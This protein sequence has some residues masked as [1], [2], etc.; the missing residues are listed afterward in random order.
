MKKSFYVVFFKNIKGLFLVKIQD[1]LYICLIMIT[2]Q[3]YSFNCANGFIAPQTSGVLQTAF[4]DEKE[5]VLVYQS[6]ISLNNSEVRFN[7]ALFANN[8]QSNNGNSAY[9]F[10]PVN[11]STVLGVDIDLA[12]NKINDSLLLESA[13]INFTDY[14]NFTITL[15][16]F[17]TYDL[18]NYISTIN[19]NN[20]KRLLAG[21]VNA[22]LLQ[23]NIPSAYNSPKYLGL[24]VMHK[25]NSTA[26]TTDRYDYLPIQATFLNF[27]VMNTPIFDLV[28]DGQPANVVSIDSPTTINFKVNYSNTIHKIKF[29]VIDFTNATNNNIDFLTAYRALLTDVSATITQS[30]ANTYNAF[31]IVPNTQ[32]INGNTYYIIA[33]C[34]DTVNNVVNSFVSEAF[35][36]AGT[37]LCKPIVNS[38]FK[39]YLNAFLPSNI[40]TSPYDRL[41]S[42]IKYTNNCSN[43]ET[44]TLEYD[45][46]ILSITNNN[47]TYTSS[48]SR[49][50]ATKLANTTTIVF[51]F[52]V[53]S[54]WANSEIILNWRVVNDKE[55]TDV[56]ILQR[57]EVQEFQ[58]I[59]PIKLIDTKLYDLSDTEIIVDEL[60]TYQ[61]DDF[62]IETIA[63]DATAY[64]QLAI[65]DNGGDISEE[66]S[67]AG[68]LPQL[69]TINLSD[70][71][72]DFVATKAR[73]KASYN[74][75]FGGILASIAKKKVDL[76][77]Q[78]HSFYIRKSFI[79]TDV[80]TR[81]Y[82][83]IPIATTVF[84]FDII[85][86]LGATTDCFFKARQGATPFDSLPLLTK[87]QTIDFLVN[88][89]GDVD[90]LPYP[91]LQSGVSDCT[92]LFQYLVFGIEPLTMT[93]FARLNNSNSVDTVIGFDNKIEI[94]SVSGLFGDTL[95]NIRTDYTVAW[96]IG[97]AFNLANINAAILALT[98][99]RFELQLIN[100]GNSVITITYRYL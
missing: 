7:I 91:I 55:Y 75:T 40:K 57:I 65:F 87:A 10:M 95:Y 97:T 1:Y 99:N 41:R 36:A 68:E 26:T 30:P 73:F 89:T 23:D 45:S 93:I 80:Y 53:E 17:N 39:D 43:I 88:R 90:I 92:L 84:D 19:P 25:T 4:A 82:L 49:L 77:Y 94:L 52:R 96:G 85:D 54:S 62:V 11:A 13:T 63:N 48:D 2:L 22:T 28:V 71:D 9:Y 64:K 8:F 6:D 27:G 29:F 15:R 81:L 79:D 70:V 46:N 42:I 14:S 56:V 44:I 67:F 21:S 3:S 35:T 69:S 33:V 38:Y 32:F 100:T 34:Y 50:T 16:F 74:R 78:R 58:D 20:S 51:D 98:T 61:D 72:I 83:T 31:Q 24:W 47:G 5:L 76:Y 12:T 86:V 66:E 18:A 60:C 37:A 59:T